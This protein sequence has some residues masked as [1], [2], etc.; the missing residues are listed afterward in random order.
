P[1]LNADGQINSQDSLMAQ[2]VYGSPEN[3]LL[4]EMVMPAG[5]DFNPFGGPMTSSN[6][7]TPGRPPCD[8]RHPGVDS[9]T[10]DNNAGDPIYSI[11]YGRV[12]RTG[13][14]VPALDGTGAAGG[15]GHYV[16]IEHD[17]YGKKLYSVYAHNG[18]V[19]VNPGDIVSGGDQIATMGNSGTSIVH[20]H[21]EIRQATNVDL[22]ATNPFVSQTYWPS[23]VTQLNA[24]FVDLGSVFGYHNSYS[25]W[26]QTH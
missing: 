25:K 8:A 6:C 22:D 11:A 15:F 3:I 21:F 12:V 24:N 23:T 18:S 7:D 1:D 5:T 2:W 9:S 14:T 19:L 16:I 4:K 20:L 17:V 10:S 13:A 26:A